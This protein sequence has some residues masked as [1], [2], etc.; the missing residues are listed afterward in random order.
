[1]RLRNAET[2]DADAFA[3]KLGADLSPDF[4]QV[5]R[6]VSRRAAVEFRVVPPV[7][8]ELLV[9]AARAGQR[10][11]AA[12]MPVYPADFVKAAHARHQ[13]HAAAGGFG[14]LFRPYL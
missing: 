11:H 7:G 14:Q 1:M 4:L 6:A 3:V 5:V 9:K 12:E 13:F 8:G 10:N 2:V